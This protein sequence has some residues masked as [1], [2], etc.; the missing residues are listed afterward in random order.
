MTNEKV[1][2]I[3]KNQFKAYKYKTMKVSLAIACIVLITLFNNIKAQNIGTNIG[4]IAPEIYLESID[5]DSISLY[6]LRGKVVLI[7]FWASWCGPCRIQNPIKVRAYNEFK[8][9]NFSIGDGFTIYSVSL[10][11]NK[12]SWENEAQRSN[13]EWYHVSDLRHWNS[14]PAIQYAVNSIPANFLIDENGIIVARN[15]RGNSLIETL[16]RFV[17]ADPI[18]EINNTLCEL[19]EAVKKLEND[20]NYKNNS[21][22]IMRINRNINN[23]KKQLEKLEN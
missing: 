16:E 6:S 9:Q 12:N 2:Q 14:Q 22:N 13:M 17:T 20:E 21:R 19:K 10:D 3:T 5:G 23:I 8:N 11:R 1:Y 15:L 18:V 7:D 4:D